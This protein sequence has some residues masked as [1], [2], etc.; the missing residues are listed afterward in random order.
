MIYSMYNKLKIEY[1]MNFRLNKEHFLTIIPSI[2]INL[3]KFFLIFSKKL[4]Q[5]M[6]KIFSKKISR[7]N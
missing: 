6:K 5:I 7:N 3:K 4:I 1:K 2:F